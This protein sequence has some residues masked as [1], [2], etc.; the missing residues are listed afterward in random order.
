MFPR[1]FG[2]TARTAPWGRGGTDKPADGWFCGNSLC[3]GAQ[4]SCGFPL[5]F[6]HCYGCIFYALQLGWSNEPLK[7]ISESQIAAI[8]W[9]LILC[10]VLIRLLC[11]FPFPALRPA[12][13][14]D[15]VPLRFTPYFNRNA[16]KRKGAS[17][18]LHPRNNH[19][20]TYLKS[21]GN[22]AKPLLNCVT[23]TTQ[24]PSGAVFCV[25]QLN[26]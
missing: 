23:T 14:R 17:R 9:R 7:V 1:L 26:R 2:G 21:S 20:L 4:S 11:P 24:P 8:G 19:Y 5:G 15:A 18:S 10:A 16:Q 13:H 3:L 22:T 6:R 25:F 12:A